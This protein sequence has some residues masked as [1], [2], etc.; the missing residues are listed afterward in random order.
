MCRN[1]LIINIFT[2]RLETFG[3]VLMV[4]VVA[5]GAFVSLSA[6]TVPVAAFVL[7][8]ACTVV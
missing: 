7:S 5:L 4:V 3:Y 8:A 2:I 6:D 1:F